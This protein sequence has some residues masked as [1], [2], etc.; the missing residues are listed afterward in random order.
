MCI[1]T[2]E[3]VDTHESYGFFGKVVATVDV[4]GKTDTEAVIEGVA[5]M[6]EMGDP[7]GKIFSL[8]YIEEVPAA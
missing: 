3:I 7:E 1:T 2:V 6:A 5:L 8:R 4:R